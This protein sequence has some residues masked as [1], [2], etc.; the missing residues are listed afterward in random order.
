M[1]ITADH[2]RHI[3]AILTLPFAVIIVAPTLLL[4]VFAA[5]DTRWNPAPAAYALV[6]FVGLVLLLLGMVLLV[7]TVHLFASAGEGT[8][9]PWDPPRHLVVRGPYRYVRNPMIVGV[10]M[11]LAG[12]S[13]LTGSLA[14]A[15]FTLFFFALNHL[16]FVYFEEPGLRKRFGRDY[17]RYRQAVPCWWPRATPWQE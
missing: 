13:V 15:L 12:E 1:K 16:H 3:R 17:E 9:A 2:A 6:F 4:A 14:V 10:G 5:V 11:T 7:V 8:L